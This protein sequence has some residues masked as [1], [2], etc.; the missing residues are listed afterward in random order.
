[1]EQTDTR[2]PTHNREIIFAIRGHCNYSC[3]YCVGHHTKTA[4]ATYDLGRLER[5]YASLDAF[6]VTSFECAYGEPTIHP[7]S[8]DILEI[9][10][11]TGTASLP[12]NNSIDPALWL[13]PTHPKRIYVRAALHPQGEADIDGFIERLLYVKAHKVP[14]VVIFVAHPARLGKFRHYRDLII[15]SGLL[16]DPAPF[17]GEYEG[18]LYPYAYT[19][20]ELKEL[21]L[22]Q[23]K[24]VWWYHRLVPEMSIRDFSGIPCNAGYSSILIDENQEIR[25]CLYDRVPLKKALDQPLPCTVGH[26]GCG[27]LLEE[28]NTQDLFFWNR[29]RPHAGLGVIEGAEEE[30]QD[31]L[32]ERNSRK[33]RELMTRFGKMPACG[34]SCAGGCAK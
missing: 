14:S 8:R 34:A 33:Y 1:M 13:P 12:T 16:I 28:L 21:G 30:P 10:T 4:V 2:N 9:I 18:K 15:K 24:N 27:L 5:F 11:R 22:E 3:H 19:A 31:V 7:Q 25:R 17:Q 32:Y 26:C 6:T 29:W 20:E 23:D